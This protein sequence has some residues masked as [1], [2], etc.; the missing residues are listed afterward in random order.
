[1]PNKL[2]HHPLHKTLHLFLIRLSVIIHPLNDDSA[3]QLSRSCACEDLVLAE[4]VKCW[5]LGLFERL[6]VVWYWLAGLLSEGDFL[7]VY[8]A[9]QWMGALFDL[10]LQTDYVGWWVVGIIRLNDVLLLIKLTTTTD[11]IR[12][13]ATIL[14]INHYFHLFLSILRFLYPVNVGFIIYVN[15][16]VNWSRY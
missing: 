9:G 5:L 13:V 3:H 8:W 15:V 14:I 11:N 1:M 12:I 7:T 2:P 10:L 16:H 4:Y 6:L